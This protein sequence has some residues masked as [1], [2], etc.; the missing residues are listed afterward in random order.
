MT[1]V[2][3][4]IDGQMEAPLLFGWSEVPYDGA[5][6]EIGGDLYTVKPGG[7]TYGRDPIEGGDLV[8]VILVPKKTK[9]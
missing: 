2:R 9:R 5:N 4:Y 6:V 1:I 3:F 7:V 8:T